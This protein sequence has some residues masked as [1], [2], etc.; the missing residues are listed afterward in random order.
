MNN[1]FFGYSGLKYSS[2]IIS[3]GTH[4]CQQPGVYILQWKFSNSGTSRQ[5]LKIQNKCKLMLYYDILP[6]KDFRYVPCAFV[7]F[8]IIHRIAV[9]HICLA[10]EI[11]YKKYKKHRTGNIK[12][13]HDASVTTLHIK[14]LR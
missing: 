6:S 5:S 9:K 11:C 14:N 7:R 12:Q 8:L 3:Q 13:Q 10:S 1:R 2:F 4:I